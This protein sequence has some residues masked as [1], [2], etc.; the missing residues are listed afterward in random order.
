MVTPAAKREAVA[1]LRATFKMSERRACTVVGANPMT[2][3]YRSVRRPDGQLRERLRALAHERRRFGYRRLH[4]L[5]RREGYAL[6]HKRLFRLYREERLTVRK[7][8]G[9]KRAVGTRAPLAV[10]LRPNERWSLDFVSDQLACGRRLRILTVV[11]DRTREVPGA[12]RRHLALRRAG[13]PRARPARCRTRPAD[14]DRQ[15]QRH[16]ADR[17][18]D[19][20]TGRRASGR[21]AL[22]CARKADPERL[23]R[24][25]QRPPARRA[26][27]RG[28]VP[29]A[30]HARAVLAAWRAD[31][32]TTRPHSRLGWLTPNDYAAA[33]LRPRRSHDLSNL[34]GFGLPRLPT[35]TAEF[36]AP[37]DRVGGNVTREPAAGPSAA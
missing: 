3:R 11:D 20:L 8:G 24:E 10:P 28:P 18:R 34:D 31:Y 32:K 21:L 2:V 16:R 25:L 9:R 7:R 35:S 36:Q 12:G 13:C 22:H 5:L 4:A 15:R 30:P 37:L 17:E 14:D 23:H 27:E 1:H 6:N 33:I 29:L 26:L 19:P